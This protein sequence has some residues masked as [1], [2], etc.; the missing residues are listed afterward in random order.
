MYFSDSPSTRPRFPCQTDPPTTWDAMILSVLS[1][2]DN[3]NFRYRLNRMI[4][5]G[6][7]S[8]I[9]FANETHYRIFYRGS[10]QLRQDRPY[11]LAVVYLLSSCKR[12]WSRVCSDKLP[13]EIVSDDKAIGKV[14]GN[15][16]TIYSFAKDLHTGSRHISVGDM[17]DVLL[18][19]D[20]QF[21]LICNAITIHSFGVAALDFMPNES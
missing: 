10:K 2:L 18:I 11:M 9:F 13:S 5:R 16:Y 6:K 14:N 4:T 20:K 7:P 12:L 21:V 17:A 19:P 1:D 15:I 3:D 8:G